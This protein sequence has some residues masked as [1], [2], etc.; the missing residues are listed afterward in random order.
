MS[1]PGGGWMRSAVANV[2]VMLPYHAVDSLLVFLY[3]ML[4]ARSLGAHDF[5][6]FATGVAIGALLFLVMD[7]GSSILVV[8][9]VASNRPVASA[10]KSAMVMKLLVTLGLGVMSGLMGIGRISWSPLL[11]LFGLLCAAE[12]MR[13]LLTHL[14]AVLLGQNRTPAVAVIGLLEKATVLAVITAW[15]LWGGTLTLTAVGLALLVGRSAP[16]LIGVLLTREVWSGGSIHPSHAIRYSISSRQVGLFVFSE[17]L[18]IYCLPILISVGAGMAATGQFQ[19]AFKVLLAPV[20]F[21]TAF[22]S[23]LYPVVAGMGAAPRAQTRRTVSLGLLIVCA[24]ACWFGLLLLFQ[25]GS[26]VLLVFGESFRPAGALLQA[27]APVA[28]LFGIWQFCLHVLT[29]LNHERVVLRASF[30]CTLTV[31]VL[32]PILGALAGLRGIPPALLAGFT[33]ASLAYLPFLFRQ[34][35]VDLA[36][37]RPIPLLTAAMVTMGGLFLAQFWVPISPLRGAFLTCGILTALLPT[38]MLLFGALPI[39]P[40]RVAL[41]GRFS[42]EMQE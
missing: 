4:I 6:L 25:G 10:L 41:R 39:E 3:T 36:I 40:L 1:A 12:G 14:Q 31:C 9:D 23:A 18:L 28:V 21:F 20:S 26:I 2:S 35:L 38:A 17:R 13:S 19:A 27:L 22:A 33:L 7:F 11:A 30:A 29:G 16:A 32:T 24:A 8:R 34:R 5:G 15:I 42:P 37:L